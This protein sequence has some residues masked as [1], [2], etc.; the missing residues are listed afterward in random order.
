MGIAVIIFTLMSF[1]YKYV[2]EEGEND[3]KKIDEQIS[4]S[5]SSSDED[6]DV[7]GSGTGEKSTTVL[8]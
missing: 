5:L 4:S 3:K 8:E 6:D 1:G 2:D 7:E